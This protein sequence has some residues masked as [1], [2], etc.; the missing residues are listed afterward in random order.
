[1]NQRWFFFPWR[2]LNVKDYRAYTEL[3]TKSIFIHGNRSRVRFDYYDKKTNP[4]ELGDLIFIIS[5]VYN[6]RK[7]FEKITINQFKKD[8]KTQKHILEYKQQE[9][10]LF[11]VKI[12]NLYRGQGSY[13]KEIL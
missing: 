10:T 5:I 2:N 11:V 3:S 1:M 4:V 12:S 9:T 8:E 7:Y 6:K 13:P